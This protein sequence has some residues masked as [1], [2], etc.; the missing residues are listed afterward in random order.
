[1]KLAIA[2]DSAGAPLAR[3]LYDYL[4]SRDGLEVTELSRPEAGGDEFYADLAE[5]VC[6]H[7]LDGTYER[8]ILVCGTGIGVC[9]AANKVPGLRAALT[10][11]AY[12]AAKAAT[13]NNAQVI[14]MGARVVAGELAKTIADAWLASAFDPRGRSADNVRA[15]DRVDAKYSKAQG[16]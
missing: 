3:V 14:T 1:M 13:S 10:H 2:G 12:S 5:R 15:I 8:A 7:V 4:N 16:T 11:D 6:R 9:I